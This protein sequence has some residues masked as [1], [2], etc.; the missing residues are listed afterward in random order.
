MDIEQIKKLP[1][2]YRITHKLVADDFIGRGKEIDL[3]RKLLEEHKVSGKLSNVIVSGAKSIG[4]STMLY[5]YKQILGDYSFAAFEIEL[6]KQAG[7][8]NG[9]DFFY[10]LINYLFLNY[11]NPE[12][13]LFNPQQQEIWFSLTRGRYEHASGYVERKI[14]F[15]TKYANYKKGAREDI[16]YKDLEVDFKEIIS[17]LISSRL[18][19]A[20]L[21]ILIDEFQELSQNIPLLDILRQL[22]HNVPHLIVIGA[23]VP[24]FLEN[25][26]FEKM[27]RISAPVVLVDLKTQ[28]VY[29]LAL[30]PLQKNF[31]L[32]R[33]EAESLFDRKSLWELVKRTG[34][35]PLHVQVLCGSMF[36]FFSENSECKVLKLNRPVMDEVMQYYSMVSDKSRK[37]QNSL[38]TCSRDKLEIFSRIYRYEGFTLRQ[39]ILCKL[40][41]QPITSEAE[42]SVR[43]LI[44]QD[45]K[46]IRDLELFEFKGD[47]LKF[48]EVES[49]AIDKL[50]NVRYL[51]IGDKIDKLYA[52]YFY[53]T[54]TNGQ[55]LNHDSEQG[56]EGCLAQKLSRTICCQTMESK[57]NKDVTED[58][59][60]H[61]IS[62]SAISSQ[63]THSDIKADFRNLAKSA[64]DKSEDSA[65]KV[66]EISKKYQLDYPS[67]LARALNYGGYY[68]LFSAVK[69]RG[70]EQLIINYLPIKKDKIDE[71]KGNFGELIDFA[72][73]IKG[74]LSEYMV[75]IH[76]MYLCQVRFEPLLYIF[77]IDIT[78]IR[79]QLFQKAKE[80]NF[81]AAVKLAEQAHFLDVSVK[82]DYVEINVHATNNHAFCLMNLNEHKKAEEFLKKISDKYLLAKL[83]LAY[84][85]FIRNGES[86]AESETILKQILRK[87]LGEDEELG[88][89]HLMLDHPQLTEQEKIAEGITIAQTAAIN[90]AL[91]YAKKKE[92]DSN[93]NSILKKVVFG[94]HV[95]CIKK[96]AESWIAY[97][98]GDVVKAISIAKDGLA[99]CDR[100]NYLYPCLVKDIKIFESQGKM[101]PEKL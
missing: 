3:L 19:L 2:P 1:N 70:K 7:A 25:S 40:A 81:E 55:D 95:S 26:S 86:A 66:M 90:L 22:S 48:D 82:K 74:P 96:R 54:L 75:T 88:L 47:L 32:N 98:K 97:Y 65:K 101:L 50:A 13:A 68:I 79:K 28:D 58:E 37:I 49:L 72:Q 87:K 43:K 10:D 64:M 85:Y 77:S 56:F 41:F 35:N 42:E 8:V 78:A 53:K 24:I 89:I 91:I 12:S 33:Y 36:K 93:I 52:A 38:N 30:G 11:S 62:S 46:E 4:K 51:F 44:F 9:F 29:D 84:I 14:S 31:G 45:F 21:A 15:A 39:V 73:E 92:V 61:A 63:L 17:E 83:N 99:N 57:V 18:Q 76:W 27:I 16:S 80:R 71:L 6:P 94:Q 60:F 34:G 69:I 59:E 67:N 23:G 100:E 20:G 5:R